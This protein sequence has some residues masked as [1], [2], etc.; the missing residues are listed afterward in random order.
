MNGVRKNSNGF[1]LVELL[2]AMALGLLVMAA[3]ASL[4][5]TGLNS[6]MLITQRA[7]TQ[8]NMR[9]GLDLMVKD[10]SMAGAG[11]PSGG[12]QLPSGGGSSA[13]KFSDRERAARPDK[14]PI[15][16]SWRQ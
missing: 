15:S 2:V 6:V 4:F 10:I 5:K 7:E 1:T 16:S 14:T 11:L 3:M 9:A 12:I 8:H 13:S